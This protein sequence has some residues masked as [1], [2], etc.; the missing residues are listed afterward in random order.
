MVCTD[1]QVAENSGETPHLWS[2]VTVW[3]EPGG[4]T[5]WIARA[6]T[7]CPDHASARFECFQVAIGEPRNHCVQRNAVGEIISANGYAHLSVMISAELFDT[8][9]RCDRVRSASPMVVSDPIALELVLALVEA[10]SLYNTSPY[11][12]GYIV[13][14]LCAQ[15]LA[16]EATSSV[17]SSHPG[18]GFEPWQQKRLEAALS[19]IGNRKLSLEFF[20]TRCGLSVCHFARL[21]KLTYGVSFYQ[22]VIQRKIVRACE[23]LLETVEPVSQIAL[24]CGF[25]DQSSF[26]R[27]FSAEVGTSPAAWREAS[28]QKPTIN[29]RDRCRSL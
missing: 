24:E 22:Y 21:F 28:L 15:L 4:G 6:T 18:T 17:A 9:G 27:R 5:I 1:Q 7:V 26:T 29:P 16:T 12:K 19:D 13:T 11:T 25:S 8:L 20:A 10:H 3:R 14:M 23:L 2:G